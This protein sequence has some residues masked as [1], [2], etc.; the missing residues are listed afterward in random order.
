MRPGFFSLDRAD[1]LARPHQQSRRGGSGLL[2]RLADLGQCNCCRGADRRVEL[3]G[4]FQ[5][6]RLAVVRGRARHDT[7]R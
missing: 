4:Q 6:F 3:V 7:G 5:A 2:F 1:R